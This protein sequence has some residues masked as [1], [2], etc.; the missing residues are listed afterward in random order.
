MPSCDRVRENES[1]ADTR[2]IPLWDTCM[3]R[4]ARR[5]V[6]VAPRPHREG[7]RRTALEKQRGVVMRASPRAI[8]LGRAPCIPHV[9]RERRRWHKLAQVKVPRLSRTPQDRRDRARTGLVSLL[10]GAPRSVRWRCVAHAVGVLRRSNG[11]TFR[12]R[13]PF[14]SDAARPRRPDAS[15]PN[16][17]DESCSELW[18]GSL[19]SREAGITTAFTSSRS[20]AKLFIRYSVRATYDAHDH[21]NRHA[22]CHDDEP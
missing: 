7:C 20:A 16:V 13:T 6:D 2:R 11:R 4:G 9:T 22:T 10:R 19:L 1:T 3:K 5:P 12:K 18:A 15:S 21:A 8:G 17:E 14:H